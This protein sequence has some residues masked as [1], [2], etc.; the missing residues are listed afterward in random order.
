[1]ILMMSI[2]L[3]VAGCGTSAD[4]RH[5]SVDFDTINSVQ[6]TLN[7][8]VDDAQEGDLSVDISALNTEQEALDAVEVEENTDILESVIIQ[9]VNT[10]LTEG[11][12]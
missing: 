6:E 12:E 9:E 8:I 11:F 3:F 10:T 1:M 4:D 7:D 2:G 5:E